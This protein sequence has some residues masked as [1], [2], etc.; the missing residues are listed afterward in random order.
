MASPSLPLHE[1][2]EDPTFRA[3]VDLLDRG[4]VE[5]L[6]RHL[7]SHPDLVRQRVRFDDSNYRYFARP[8]LIEFIAENPIRHDRLPPNIVYVAQA[9]LD[10]PG[11]R[12]RA[13]LD[14]TLEL[15]SSGR[16]AREHGVQVPLIDLL[17]RAGADPDRAMPAALAHGEFDAV[18]ALIAQG[19]VVDLTVAAATGRTEAVRRLLAAAD[20]ESRHRGLALA[21]QHGHADAVIALVEAGEDPDRYNPAG[22]HAHSTPLH[23]AAVAGHTEVVRL[24]VERGARLDIRDTLY[25]GT[26]L[27]W[28][29]FGGQRSIADYL[30]SRSA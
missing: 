6:R 20:G 16:V 29:E 12:D 10:M 21:A 28:A 19:A 18:A 22:C 15:V 30:R 14:S 7:V 25:N 2:I 8:T 9:I 17:C 5:G 4:D 1:Q 11:G 3:A 26:P 13:S 27:A 23:Q 24:L